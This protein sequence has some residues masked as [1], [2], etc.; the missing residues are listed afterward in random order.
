MLSSDKGRGTDMEQQQPLPVTV[1][2]PGQDD[3]K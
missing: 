2:L 1:G 3:P